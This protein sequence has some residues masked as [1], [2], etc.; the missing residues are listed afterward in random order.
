MVFEPSPPSWATDKHGLLGAPGFHVYAPRSFQGLGARRTLPFSG[1]PPCL[2]AQQRSWMVLRLRALGSQWAMG[3]ATLPPGFLPSAPITTVDVSDELLTSNYFAAVGPFTLAHSGSSPAMVPEA[4]STV[5]IFCTGASRGEEARDRTKWLIKCTPQCY[6]PTGCLMELAHGDALERPA[7]LSMAGRHV[8][9]LLSPSPVQRLAAS[10]LRVKGPAGPAATEAFRD[11]QTT[12]ADSHLQQPHPACVTALCIA[13]ATQIPAPFRLE[14]FSAGSYTGALLAVL[15]QWLWEP[16]L[17]S[18]ELGVDEMETDD[19]AP[20]RS[21]V[22]L[23]ALGMPD[24]V[25]SALLGTPYR[26]FLLH[27]DRDALCPWP[28]DLVTRERLCSSPSVQRG[29]FV[30]LRNAPAGFFGDKGHAYDHLLAELDALPEVV[31]VE[32][33][34][35]YMPLLDPATELTLAFQFL[36]VHRS[37]ELR[38]GPHDEVLAALFPHPCTAESLQRVAHI[39]ALPRALR[40]S[41]LRAT[42]HSFSGASYELRQWLLDQARLDSV[43]S[44]DPEGLSLPLPVQRALNARPLELVVDFLHFQLFSKGTAMLDSGTAMRREPKQG[45]RTGDLET[46][47]LHSPAQLSITVYANT[48]S[49]AYLLQLAA[50]NDTGWF[51]HHPHGQSPPQEGSVLRLSLGDAGEITGVYIKSQVPSSNKR[52]SP[53]VK[54]LKKVSP[55]AVDFLVPTW[56]A[57]LGA[58][59]SRQTSPVLSLLLT[60]VACAKRGGGLDLFHKVLCLPLA[61]V[62][63]AIG[64]PADPGLPPLPGPATHFGAEVH[65]VLLFLQACHEVATGQAIFDVSEF[66]EDSYWS[67]RQRLADI[68][69]FAAA[70]ACPRDAFAQNWQV[71]QPLVNVEYYRMASLLGRTFCS[72]ISTMLSDPDGLLVGHVLAILTA[73]ATGRSGVAPCVF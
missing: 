25:F 24:W 63:L 68:R 73:R 44:N 14:G 2:S 3:L 65:V 45:M 43:D 46:R 5:H 58:P 15:L 21:T 69:R 37:T 50:P 31:D 32:A 17:R 23:G 42:P 61:R 8:S 16:G 66:N 70:T 71:A 28:L 49:G 39:T 4:P 19:P 36:H 11:L 52:A 40:D 18:G 30:W 57:C 12:P 47:R 38:K 20:I 27:H 62:P 53:D 33:D 41:L 56:P 59:P 60:Q 34:K 9:L 54:R 10:L 64:L 51:T 1:A 13:M 7:R 48:S 29:K 6:G 22:A 72:H 35:G 67:L 26:V 55:R